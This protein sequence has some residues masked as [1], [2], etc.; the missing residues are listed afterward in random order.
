MIQS[1][2]GESSGGEFFGLG[3]PQQCIKTPHPS[4]YKLF[5]Y[6]PTN[7]HRF[8]RSLSEFIDQQMPRDPSINKDPIVY[9][10][11]SFVLD[12][13]N[14][15]DLD[16]E[17]SNVS[18]EHLQS[19]FA[20][21]EGV[22]NIKKVT[23]TKAGEDG[24][25][26]SSR[27]DFG[28]VFIAVSLVVGDESSENDL[29][30]SISIPML[31]SPDSTRYDRNS[32]I[33][34]PTLSFF[35]A[36]K[37]REFAHKALGYNRM[38]GE[39]GEIIDP[40]AGIECLGDDPTLKI[41][42]PDSFKN[43]PVE[44]Y[45]AIKVMAE[46]SSQGK[47]MRPDL[48]SFTVLKEMASQSLSLYDIKSLRPQRI[49]V[50]RESLFTSSAKPSYCLRLARSLGLLKRD[51]T[52]VGELIED[53]ANADEDL[54]LE[55][56]R[57][58]DKI[59]GTCRSEKFTGAQF[60]EPVFLVLGL[61]LA[62]AGNDLGLE[63]VEELCDKNGFNTCLVASFLCRGFSNLYPGLEDKMKRI[64]QELKK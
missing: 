53:I 17:I 63:R 59:W 8:F 14:A 27:G 7:P 21:K 54:F 16:I 28:N 36:S 30:V 64:F 61:Y 1:D 49:E 23:L 48:Q 41:L 32:V 56:G 40:H 4:L 24:I 38:V 51:F 62:K 5:H 13:E 19:F 9:A 55:I 35:E 34:D 2:L 60:L 42:S 50:A 29:N 33:Y 44:L 18:W 15:H 20:D 52:K 57:S 12:P 39:F 22:F 47:V 3:N 46:N 31:V 6:P 10:V 26:D 45:R 11:G 37:R 58:L 25:I 43:D